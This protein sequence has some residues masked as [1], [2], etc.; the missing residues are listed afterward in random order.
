MKNSVITYNF[1]SSSKSNILKFL[2]KYLKLSKIEFIYDFTVDEWNRNQKT[3]LKNISTKF[4]S[5][6]II[7]SSVLGEDSLESSQAGNFQSI[8]SRQKLKSML[9]ISFIAYIHLYLHCF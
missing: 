3:I 4:D 1:E 6:I 7:R 2:Q 5:K 8:F 9:I